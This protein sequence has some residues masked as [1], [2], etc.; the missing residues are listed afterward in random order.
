[1]IEP[2]VCD[3]GH[4]QLAEIRRVVLGGG[5]PVGLCRRDYRQRFPMKDWPAWDTFPLVAPGGLIR[6]PCA[7]CGRR[8]EHWQPTSTSPKAQCLGCGQWKMLR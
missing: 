1:M 8:K 3:D 6:R 2:N 5:R 7:T 4:R